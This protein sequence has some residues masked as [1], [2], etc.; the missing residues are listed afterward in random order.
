MTPTSPP[1]SPGWGDRSAQSREIV[2]TEWVGD[3]RGVVSVL[4][5]AVL[6]VGL[7]LATGAARLGAVLVARARAET[8]ADAA[9]L[10]A[11][12]ALALGR[13]D[14]VAAARAI[15]ARND[16]E[17]LDCDCEGSHAQVRVAVRVRGFAGA[18]RVTAKA[19]AEV[20]TDCIVACTADG[21]ARLEG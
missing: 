7:V 12:D 8:A 19:R 6:V 5:V 18:G 20:G 16:A 21:R 14:P 10:A 3:E 11:A 4:V 13:R 2:P 1:P 17:L 15:A 9:A